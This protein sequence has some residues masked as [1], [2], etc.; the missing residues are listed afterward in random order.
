[1][2]EAGAA[3]TASQIARETRA[4]G[5]AGQIARET[6]AAGA[7]GQI[8]RGAGTAGAA[9]QIVRE[10][11]AAGAADQISRETGTAGTAGQPARETEKRPAGEPSGN[12]KGDGGKQKRSA[13]L[14]AAAGFIGVLLCAGIAFYVYAAQAYKTV[15]FPN[16]VI[17]G[18]DVSDRTVDEVKAAFSAGADNYRLTVLPRGGEGEEISG[19][20]I[21][22]HTVFDGK[23]EDILEA[24]NPYNW[25][26]HL[27]KSRE[28][29]IGTMLKWDEEALCQAVES[30]ECMDESAMAE[31]RDAY[32]SDYIEG[33]GYQVVPEEEGTALKAEAVQTAAAAAVRNLDPEISLEELKCYEEPSVRSDDPSLAAE[34]DARNR[35][36]NVTVT[37]TFG[38]QTEVLNGSRIHQWLTG[39]GTDL[40]LDETMIA[41]YVSEL[42]AAHNT[43]YKTRAFKTSYGPTVNV[44]GSYGW[45]INQKEE[46]V[47]LKAVLEAGESVTREPVYAQTA[48]AHGAADYG[49]TYAE[50]NLTAQHLLFYK[51]GVKILESDFV[52]GN[53]SK[54]HT[55][56]AGL[57]SLTYKQRDAVLKGEGYA[58]PV[59][60]WMPFNG[61]IGFHDA[62]WRSSFGGSIYKTGGSHGCVNMPYAAA[63]ELF[64]NVYAG[65][66]VICYNLPGTESKAPTKASGRPPSSGQ[67]VQ[68][69]QPA[70]QPTQ[71]APQE[72][73]QATQPAPQATQPAP[74]ETPQATQPAP[75]ETP[76]PETPAGPGPEITPV[77]NG[78]TAATQGYGPAFDNVQPTEGRGPGVP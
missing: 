69:T 36:V 9:G 60:F 63:K 59:K 61:G 42:A 11:R 77:E 15:F 14:P 5:A 49:N 7:A 75:Q 41:E 16:T 12:Q 46:T 4:A 37:Y 54:G 31:P 66:P 55:T 72:T 71:P 44:S 73:P 68:P 20:D 40:S 29:Q 76:T 18:A 56:P 67:T 43:A 34:R 62:S 27:R 48:A 39:S 38:D 25:I 64:E 32:L 50:V 17:N 3:G 2:G 10:T 51:D 65:M 30:L 23:L 19:R 53:V 45:R 35:Y 78:T 21:G 57:Y 52:S 47:Q 70:P 33:Q 24:Q 58:S 26:F 1:M 8:A 13:W 22:L 6:G 28:Y 74:Q